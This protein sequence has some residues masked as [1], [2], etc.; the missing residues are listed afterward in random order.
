MAN[1]SQHQDLAGSRPQTASRS[2]A[3][4]DAKLPAAFDLVTTS[5]GS[6]QGAICHVHRRDG[7]R[8]TRDTPAKRTGSHTVWRRSCGRPFTVYYPST[9][10]KLL[11]APQGSALK[12]DDRWQ[13]RQD[14]VLG[15]RRSRL[16]NSHVV[17]SCLSRT[18]VIQ[19]ASTG[20]P[21]LY[22]SEPSTT[23]GVAAVPA[24]EQTRQAT[25][26]T[27]LRPPDIDQTVAIP[28]P[29]PPVHRRSRPLRRTS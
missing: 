25:G 5:Q 11:T 13:R 26:L 17:S 27:A 22:R 9:T 21:H 4:Q 10:G 6:H 8:R 19:S 14:A 7:G 12:E 15:W 29:S 3:K 23:A 1:Y 28:C 16:M 20:R 2:R 18:I 24:A